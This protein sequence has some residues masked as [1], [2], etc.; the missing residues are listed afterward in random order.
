MQSTTD[1][2]TKIATNNDDNN[3]DKINLNTIDIIDNNNTIQQQQQPI[4]T[5]RVVFPWNKTV[6]FADGHGDVKPLDPLKVSMVLYGRIIWTEREADYLLSQSVEPWKK[7]LFLLTNIPYVLLALS[8]IILNRV[9]HQA[10]PP[11]FA[12][13]CASSSTYT[14]LATAVACTSIMLHTSQCRVGH[15][16]CSTSRARTLHRRRVQDRIDLAD[17][18]CASLACVGTI[19]CHGFET[20]GPRMLCVIPMF[21]LS[22]CA[23]KLGYFNSYLILH[24]IWH[25][26]SAFILVEVFV[27]QNSNLRKLLL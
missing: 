13:I 26:G 3:D 15:W 4:I 12:S 25:I 17:C 22:I 10:W 9:E 16:C 14:A 11:F 8:A 18:V 7:L 5:R 2:P 19:I 20:V 23:K 24:G 6:K 21:V 27:P 1:T